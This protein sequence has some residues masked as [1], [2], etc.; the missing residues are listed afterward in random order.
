[1]LIQT[2]LEVVMKAYVLYSC[3]FASVFAV[4]CGSDSGSSSSDKPNVEGQ[5]EKEGNKDGKSGGAQKDANAQA[6][7]LAEGKY[8]M[9]AGT[10]EYF[11]NTGVTLD[12][13]PLQVT[14][15]VNWTVEPQGGE[16]Y[17]V[18]MTGSGKVT[19]QNNVILDIR[20][21]GASDLYSFTLSATNDVRDLTP[22]QLGCPQGGNST[23]ARQLSIKPLGQK[24]F[25]YTIVEQAQG[26]RAVVS[27]TFKQD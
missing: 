13:Q 14:G 11:D 16:V 17:Q 9:S 15:D 5:K 23:A 4:S 2:Y 1:V 8:F 3:L 24:S 19:F 20:C 26:Q 7:R 6:A 27:L 21:T 18:T 10:V 22:V 12:P 25:V